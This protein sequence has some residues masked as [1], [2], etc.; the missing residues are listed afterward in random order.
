M[1]AV[2]SV[3][4]RSASGACFQQLLIC[5]LNPSENKVVL[6]RSWQTAA[7]QTSLEQSSKCLIYSSPLLFCRLFLEDTKTDSVTYSVLACGSCSFSGIKFSQRKDVVNVHLLPEVRGGHKDKHKP[8]SL[9]YVLSSQCNL[10]YEMK[11]RVRSGSHHMPHRCWALMLYRL[12]CVLVNKATVGISKTWNVLHGRPS[13][14]SFEMCQIVCVTW[15]Q[16]SPSTQ[17][18]LK[19]FLSPERSRR[20]SITDPRGL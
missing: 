6:E 10:R 19:L 9:Q 5:P 18:W 14:D 11:R 8:L 16:F 7:G 17:G 20:S 3:E 4:Y 13:P 15:P 1:V 2:R 12:R